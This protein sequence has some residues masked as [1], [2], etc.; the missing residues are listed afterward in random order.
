MRSF[1]LPL[2]PVLLLSGSPF[3]VGQDAAAQSMNPEL[4][5]QTSLVMVPV[6]VR[7]KAG[8]LVFTLKADD[9]VLTDNG[10]PQKLTMEPQNG[11]APLA[12]VVVLEV[13]GAGAREFEK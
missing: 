9:F 12:I 1:V 6:M 4:T 13:G 3:L 7:T 11:D 8:E 10:V 2:I 5:I